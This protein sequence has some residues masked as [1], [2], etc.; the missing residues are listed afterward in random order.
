MNV[1]EMIALRFARQV[2]MYSSRTHGGG[3]IFDMLN[4]L[5][6]S[7][8]YCICPDSESIEPIEIKILQE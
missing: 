3:D 7:M 2:I 5:F 4:L 8:K 1:A 6:D